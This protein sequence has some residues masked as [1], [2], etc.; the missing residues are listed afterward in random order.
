VFVVQ[1]LNQ[2]YKISTQI[3]DFFTLKA[4]KKWFSPVIMVLSCPILI[5]Y[6]EKKALMIGANSKCNFV[7]SIKKM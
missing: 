4:K 6:K 5:G 1:L 7:N 3:N 2:K